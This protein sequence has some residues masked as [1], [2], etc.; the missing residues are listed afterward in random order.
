MFNRFVV[1]FVVVATGWMITPAATQAALVVAGG[2][3]LYTN[4][5]EGA[6]MSG[7]MGGTV[8]APDGGILSSLVSGPSEYQ[9]NNFIRYQGSPTT[10]SITA[11]LSGS[12]NVGTI[13]T[14]LNLYG[15]PGTNWSNGPD[16]AFS[17][18]GSATPVASGTWTQ[19]V[20][21]GLFGGIQISTLASPQSATSV[22]MGLSNVPYYGTDTSTHY[23]DYHYF[24]AL[25]DALKPV[26][27]LT[28]TSSTPGGPQYVPTNTIQYPT[29]QVNSLNGQFYSPDA[30]PFLQINLG[31]TK[32][33][34]G[35]IVA[36]YGG[37]SGLA[38]ITIKDDLGNVVGTISGI[39]DQPL[40]LPVKFNSPVTTSYLR[41]EPTGSG[42]FALNEVIPLELPEPASLGMLAAGVGALF[43]RRS[44][45]R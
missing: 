35:V 11:T 22:K 42:T 27:T 37:S 39:A 2:A 44:R 30:S 9:Y 29:D 5:L 1:G 15:P 43:L 45:A 18:N 16:W 20:A 12:A 7:E 40:M 23:A 33:L 25:P 19:S 38:D 31:S 28:A 17:L 41:F 10:S 4:V 21:P 26:R 34:D 32:T 3:S 8:R 24:V 36:A 6:S 14:V 13:I